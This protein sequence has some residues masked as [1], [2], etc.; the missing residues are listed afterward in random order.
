MKKGLIL[1][2]ILAILLVLG[3]TIYPIKPKTNFSVSAADSFKNFEQ[4]LLEVSK[5][6]NY[7]FIEL[8]EN[9]TLENLNSTFKTKNNIQNLLT[10]YTQNKTLSKP[11]IE[12][13]CNSNDMLFI[14]NNN[15]ELGLLLPIIKY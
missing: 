5:N 14:E 2:F 4:P 6:D 8:D 7:N 11:Q 1:T 13:F 3:S 12:E 15:N 9:V 10:P